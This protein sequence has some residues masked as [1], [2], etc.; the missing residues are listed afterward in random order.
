MYGLNFYLHNNFRNFEKEQPS[1]GLF[2][3]GKEAFEKVSQH[4]GD[5]YQFT[6]LEE[7]NNKTRDGERVILLIALQKK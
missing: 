3:I 1:E 4:F 7:Y 5:D 6:L 2:L